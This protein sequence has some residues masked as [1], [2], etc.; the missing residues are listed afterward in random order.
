MEGGTKRLSSSRAERCRDKVG[1]KERERP[2][3]E[4]D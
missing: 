3:K 1:K 4:A 2:R